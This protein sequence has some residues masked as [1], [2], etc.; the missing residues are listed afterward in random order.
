MSAVWV[1]VAEAGVPPAAYQCAAGQP[2]AL[3]VDDS[4]V[5]RF[6]AGSILESRLGMRVIYAAN[7]TE[8]LRY[9]ARDEPAV[10]IT[11]LQMPDL[12]GLALVDAVRERH[13]LIP[14]VLIA[15]LYFLNRYL[16]TKKQYI[17]GVPAEATPAGG[18]VRAEFTV[19]FLP[20]T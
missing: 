5:D 14:V 13:S 1:P 8:A 7:G 20:V 19:G 17:P 16:N 11:D 9:L 15:G 3:V 4:P 18:E 10:V 6:L 12:D 2:S